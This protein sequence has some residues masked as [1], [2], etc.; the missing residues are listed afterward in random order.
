MNLGD[1]FNFLF[2]FPITNL[3]VGLYKLFVSLNIPYALGF[4]I[5][6]LT[7]V[8]RTLLAPFVSAQVRQAA[9]MQ[10]IA[11]HMAT[12]K[13]KHKN[14]KRKQQEELLKLYK[15]HGVNPAS[16]CLPMVIQMP[17]I[18]SLYNVLSTIVAVHTNDALAKVNNIL[19]FPFLRIEKM[20]DTHF[21]GLP[22]SDTPAKL[23]GISFLIILVPVL[24]G[25]LQLI[26]SAMLIPEQKQQNVKK[27][28]FQSAFQT[29]SLFLFP[30][31]IGFFSHTLPIGLSLY[32]N[33]FTIFGILQ[34]YAING[35]GK[36]GVVLR[37]AHIP[38][39]KK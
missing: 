24:T 37:K 20:W 8:I 34:Q 14:D 16:G 28:D 2:V 9:K 29:Q 23:M 33:T 36:V 3:L 7:V 30:V 25:L 32:W 26:F 4:S 18:L 6:A 11:P 10:K 15:E 1:I 19:Y 21:F 27:D 38:L 5:I 35:P 17:V 31:M 12:L 13:E 39:W 22:L